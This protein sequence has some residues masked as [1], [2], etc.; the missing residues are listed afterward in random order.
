M[1]E[2]SNGLKAIKSL[3]AA[4]KALLKAVPVDSL[5]LFQDWLKAFKEY[6]YEY[7]NDEVHFSTEPS[8]RL[9]ELQNGITELPEYPYELAE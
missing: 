3:E 5:Q 9:V 6:Y 2:I 4:E 8:Q 7:V 1:R